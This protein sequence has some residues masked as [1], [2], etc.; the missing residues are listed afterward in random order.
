MK[1]RRSL[2]VA[3]AAVSMLLCTAP[4]A[5]AAWNRPAATPNR[6]APTWI[7]QVAMWN[8]NEWP[9]SRTMADSSG[10]RLNGRIGLEVGTGVRVNGATGYRFNRLEP[11]TPPTHPGHLVTVNN[12]PA[13]NPGTRDFT[14]TVRLRTVGQFG[15]IVQKGQATVH[16]GN[17]K[18]Q[19]P[20]GIAE[21][22]FRGSNG[23]LLVRSPARLNDGRW[24][25]VRCTRGGSAITMT[26]DGSFVARKDGWTGTIANSW[27]VTIGGKP[28]CDQV[29]V[30][31]DYYAG[32][33]D[34]V[35][36]EAG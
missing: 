21:C 18:M 30:G 11:D 1:S 29:E 15:N 19:F 7:R 5:N 34:Y 4:T 2:T 25:T 13:L 3:I 33:L 24:H 23:S 17:Y 16:G 28:I 14:L 8:M 27:P 10:N 9:G 22:L 35:Q 12:S 6:P 20:G 32:D 26:V 31:C 36:I